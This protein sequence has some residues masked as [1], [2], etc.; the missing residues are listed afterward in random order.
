MRVSR[1]A[2]LQG[3]YRFALPAFLLLRWG[4]KWPRNR[5]GPERPQ[6]TFSSSSQLLP[7][8]PPTSGDLH[9]APRA[10]SGRILLPPSP[11]G[12]A[13]QQNLRS[14]YVSTTKK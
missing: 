2:R 4:E 7:P 11:A 6:E 1:Y 13:G 3:R 12:C 8:C 10:T 9:A 14:F 5:K